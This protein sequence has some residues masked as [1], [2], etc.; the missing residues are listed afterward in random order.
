MERI[1][2]MIVKGDIVRV[3]AEGKF[4]GQVAEVLEVN[5]KMNY[6]EYQL[7]VKWDGVSRPSWFGESEIELIQKEQSDVFN[8]FE[9]GFGLEQPG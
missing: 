7:A 8:V 1:T 2:E 9:A 3:L 6:R 4:E 5:Q